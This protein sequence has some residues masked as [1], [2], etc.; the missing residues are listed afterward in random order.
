MDHE[1][2]G[3]RGD[4]MGRRAPPAPLLDDERLETD[5]PDPR[6]DHD[7]AKRKAGHP[8]TA[9]DRSPKLLLDGERQRQKR[10]V[11]R[12]RGHADRES[13]PISPCARQR[14]AAAVLGPAT[15]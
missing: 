6:G 15:G 9:L 8:E 4:Q 7:R 12:D 2:G 3:Y 1:T 10:C 14:V 5:E 13:E 11:Q